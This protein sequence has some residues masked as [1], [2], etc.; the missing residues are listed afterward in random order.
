VFTDIDICTIFFDRKKST[1]KNQPISASGC[2]ATPATRVTN[3][4]GF[5]NERGF[6]PPP[7]FTTRIFH[8]QHGAEYQV[9]P[10]PKRRKYQRQPQQNLHQGLD[11]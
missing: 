9:K 6:T 8:L 7:E 5:A 2:A 4:P 3:A 1:R 11:S 10:Q